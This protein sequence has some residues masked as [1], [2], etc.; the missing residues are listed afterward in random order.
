M[1]LLSR[2]TGI[3]MTP[4]TGYSNVAMAFIE[5]DRGREMAFFQTEAYGGMDC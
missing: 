4:G 5:G 1:I 3:L 2:E